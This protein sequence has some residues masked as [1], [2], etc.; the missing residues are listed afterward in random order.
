MNVVECAATRNT[1]EKNMKR[2][3]LLLLT[4]LLLVACGGTAVD[5]AAVDEAAVPEATSP[6]AA[7]TEA[8]TAAEAEDTPAQ[9]EPPKDGDL[10]APIET[11]TDP[12]VAGVIRARDWTKGAAD[13]DIVIIEY[14]DFQ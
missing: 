9:A 6:S 1:W 2:P 13:P 8:D 14:G 12:A 11:S 10:T 5:N 7:A 4:L 3:F